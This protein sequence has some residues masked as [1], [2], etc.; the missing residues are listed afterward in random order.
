M[1]ALVALSLTGDQLALAGERT[2]DRCRGGVDRHRISGGDLR[3]VGPGR[4]VDIVR[5]EADFGG[6]AGGEEARQDEFP[7]P[8]R[9]APSPA[10]DVKPTAPG[11]QTTAITRSSPLK[12]GTSRR[13]VGLAVLQ[14]HRAGEQRHHLLR[15]DRGA[16]SAEAVAAG[17]QFA[18]LVA[19]RLDQTAVIVADVDAQ[20]AL[21]VEMLDRDRASRNR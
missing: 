17:A 19:R 14:L 21:A 10:S 5:V 11:V 15:H 3:L 1:P 6:V 18:H 9:R 8:P 16:A 2:L 12:S 4:A 13:D 20:T 7:P